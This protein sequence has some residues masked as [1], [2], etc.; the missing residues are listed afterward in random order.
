M[1]SI[2]EVIDL[3][4]S[5]KDVEAVKGMSFSVQEGSFFAF[6]GENGAG[7]STTIN[8]ITTLIQK[9]SGDVFVN[10]YQVGKQDHLIIRDI[11]V[12]FQRSML[13]KYLT[14]QEILTQRGTLYGIP[15]NILM[16]RITTLSQKIGITDI[17]HRPYGKLSGGQKRR[18][19]IV[20][21]LVNQ[22]KLLIL[23]E[24]TTGLDPY[25]RRCVWET[26]QQLK[27]EQNL[28]VFL[29]TH[30][31]EEAAGADYVVIM[32]SGQMKAEGTPEQLRLKYSSDRLYL[33]TDD[34][35]SIADILESGQHHFKI[36]RDK[37]IVSLKT[38][39]DAIAIVS[40]LKEKIQGFEVIR[41]NMEDVF[42]NVTGR[43][44]ENREVISCE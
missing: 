32:D 44:L 16:E 23:D 11:G 19:D 18:A 40:A 29:T 37:I 26:I 34:P 9:T 27:Q 6:L 33:L 41:G 21:A 4:K 7:K 15:K 42:I 3:H 12:V 36:D 38:S 39:F 8:I 22:P 13:D 43:S 31:M 25:T 17:L 5:Y 30:Y 14:V 24:P 28:T 10:Q 20:R 2:I 35:P 1:A